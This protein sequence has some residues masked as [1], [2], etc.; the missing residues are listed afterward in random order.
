M[1]HKYDMAVF[2]A[3]M[4]PLH[5]GHLAVIE[6][7]LDQAQHVVILVGSSSSPRTMRNPFTFEERKRMVEDALGLAHDRALA[8]RP[9]LEAVAGL[10][11]DEGKFMVPS[12][13]RTF[14]HLDREIAVRGL[15]FQ[16]QPGVERS[17]NLTVAKDQVAWNAASAARGATPEEMV[18]K[19]LRNQP[20]NRM[21]DTAEVCA[22][23]AFLCSDAAAAINGQGINIDGG[24]VQ[25]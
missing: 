4:Q 21:V 16:Y 18:R 25:S 3:R 23:T 14:S 17:A 20:I 12:G 22:L 2:I 19:F 11:T 5:Q 7:A 6:T 1:A 9:R 10:F 24:S 13:P 8:L 15:S